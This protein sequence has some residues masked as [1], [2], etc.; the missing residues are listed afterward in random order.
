MKTS[1]FTKNPSLP[2]QAVKIRQTRAR[3]PPTQLTAAQ[4]QQKTAAGKAI[5]HQYKFFRGIYV[6]PRLRRLTASIFDGKT[7]AWWNVRTSSWGRV[8]E[9]GRELR[10]PQAPLTRH[11]QGTATRQCDSITDHYVFYFRIFWCMEKTFMGYWIQLGDEGSMAYT[12]GYTGKLH[13]S[14]RKTS[15][16]WCLHAAGCLCDGGKK[17]F[18][19]MILAQLLHDLP[20]HASPAAQF[21]A[22]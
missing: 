18:L 22:L 2:L 11:L 21:Q 19:A 12:K 16:P 5:R 17:L 8:G 14:T 20:Y 3:C 15:S 7:R 6:V 9:S 10:T 1:R 4:V 13:Y